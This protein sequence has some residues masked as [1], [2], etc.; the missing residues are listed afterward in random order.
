MEEKLNLGSTLADAQEANPKKKEKH[1]EQIEA[2]RV[3]H[4]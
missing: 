4:Q 2:R 1:R 3:I